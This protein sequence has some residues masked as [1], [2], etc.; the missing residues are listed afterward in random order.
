MVWC[1]VVW[2]GVVWW[3]VAWR[4]VAW[5]GAAQHGTEQHGTPSVTKRAV[6]KKRCI[7]TKRCDDENIDSVGQSARVDQEPLNP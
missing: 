6:K 4:G 3:G 1:G 2:C 5:R 7:T